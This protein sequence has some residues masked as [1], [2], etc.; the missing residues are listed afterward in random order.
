MKRMKDNEIL[1]YGSGEKSLELFMEKLKNQKETDV[2]KKCYTKEIKIHPLYNNP[3]GIPALRREM[4]LN[5]DNEVLEETMASNKG[6]IIEFP[7]EHRVYV[8]MRDIAFTS[9]CGRGHVSGN[10]LRKM[11]NDEFCNVIN[12]CLQ[13]WD[14]FSLILMR[15]Y[16]VSAIHSGDETDYSILNSYELVTA[17]KNG[18]EKTF[19]NYR[20]DSAFL[21]HEMCSAEISLNDNNIMEIYKPYLLKMGYENTNTFKPMIRFST[22]DVAICGANIAPFLTNGRITVQV[23]T[24]LSLMHMRKSSV[25]DFREN[26]NSIYALFQSSLKQIEKLDEIILNYPVD[27]FVGLCKKNG[28][29]NRYA[30]EAI[31]AFEATKGKKTSALDLYMAMWEII[32]T[33]QNMGEPENKIFSAQ[34]KIA[35]VL[36]MNIKTYDKRKDLN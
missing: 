2:W 35:R 21:S 32:V 36:T 28:L 19:R 1:V 15:D 10:V 14:D 33:M 22:S 18:I 3:I 6:L 20:F 11:T 9:L 12:I 30:S 31:D 13:Q 27:C 7:L 24:P 16:K 26:V 25:A 17:L 4:Q 29:A 5:C 23:G 34:E 8:P